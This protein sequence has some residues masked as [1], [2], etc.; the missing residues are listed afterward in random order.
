[1][2]RIGKTPQNVGGATQTRKSQVTLADLYQL[3]A[4]ASRTPGQSSSMVWYSLSGDYT[5]T[6][7]T[8]VKSGAMWR[9]SLRT[10][11]E[12]NILFTVNTNDVP[13]VLNQV[14]ANC[15]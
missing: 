2:I 4:Q 1:M 11:F 3:Y 6:V 7:I 5:L 8:D 9:L 13:Q 10:K 12:Q 14:A 15:Q